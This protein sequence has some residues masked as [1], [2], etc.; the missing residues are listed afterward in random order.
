VLY[1]NKQVATIIPSRPQRRISV[2]EH[3]FYGLLQ[4]DESAVE[5]QIDTLRSGR[6]RDI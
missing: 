5:Q 6:Y 1:H 2:K 4:Q 3:P